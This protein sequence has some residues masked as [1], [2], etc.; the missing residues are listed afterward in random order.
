MNNPN[1]RRKPSP[2]TRAIFNINYRVKVKTKPS[3]HVE[4]IKQYK[5]RGGEIEKLPYFRGFTSLP[6]EFTV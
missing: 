4:T 5:L 2:E 1:M 6:L 3:K